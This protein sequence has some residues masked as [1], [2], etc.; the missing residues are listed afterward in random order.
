MSSLSAFPILAGFFF[1]LRGFNTFLILAFSSLF[2]ESFGSG[3]WPWYYVGFSILFVTTQGYL[4]ARPHLHG[5][6]FLHRALP[7]MFLL[8]LLLAVLFPHPTGWITFPA[9]I[10]YRSW[11]LHATQSFYDLVG[12]TWALQES[13]LHLPTLLA[14]GTLGSILAGVSLRLL[15]PTTGF[16]PLLVLVPLVGFASWLILSRYRPEQPTSSSASSTIPSLTSWATISPVHRRY[17]SMVFVISVM[18][19]LVVNL[20][21]FQFNAG[22][23]DLYAGIADRPARI[24][25]LLGTLNAVIEVTTLMLQAFAGRWFFTHLSLGSI[26]ALRPVLLGI[27]GVIT[28][29]LPSFWNITGFQYLSRTLTFVFMSPVWVLLLE[30]LP[31]QIRSYVRRLLNLIDC[32]TL[33]SLGLALAAWNSYNSGAQPVV[34][35]VISIIAL[36]T[37]RFNRSLLNLYPEMIRETLTDG[38]D[39][40]TTS[41]DGFKLLPPTA[42]RQ[43]LQRL[44]Q[45]SD[46]DVQLKAL[47][48]LGPLNLPEL[49]ELIRERLPQ[50]ND[51]TLVAGMTRFMLRS[52]DQ[53]QPLSAYLGSCTNP[54]RIADVLDAADQTM[55]PDFEWMFSSF[56]DHPHHRVRG[57]AVLSYLRHGVGRRLIP[58]ALEALAGL[59]EG[60]SARD[61]STA[62][63][64]MGRL[65][66]PV[67]ADALFRLV[68]DPSEDVARCAYHALASVGTQPVLEFVSKRLSQTGVRGTFARTCWNELSGQ[69]QTSLQRALAGMSLE[70]R[71]RTGIWLRALRSRL[72][73]SLLQRLLRLQPADRLPGILES[74]SESSP[75]LNTILDSC[76]IEQA[77]GSLVLNDTPL[78]EQVRRETLLQPVESLPLLLALTTPDNQMIRGWL[79]SQ[80]SGFMWDFARL[81]EI[82]ERASVQ[83]EE[84][85]KLQKTL[86]IRWS[87]FT[88]LLALLCP[89]EACSPETFRKLI[90]DDPQTSAL[91]LELL[92][93]FLP[94]TTFAM[95]SAILF[96]ARAPE[97]LRSAV[98]EAGFLDPR[99]LADHELLPEKESLP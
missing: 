11:D 4:L 6:P 41:L 70:E 9:L 59:R 25:A 80:L 27:F 3:G 12:K 77:D 68:D 82:R 58:Q 72:S 84:V 71:H 78:L 50:V 56:F 93:P 5:E 36:L 55:H 74:L 26:L 33:T 97:K 98:I 79:H 29:L 44:F 75:T 20:V 13:R 8:T 63:V 14:A 91:A 57:S 1:C 46:R 60:H 19:S 51:A 10:L 83:A 96:A 81:L 92:H 73:P 2:L 42:R 64:V 28:W 86:D 76:L 23:P 66:F 95:L 24:A 65:G 43:M 18:G 21:D 54:R 45:D 35:L 62:A 53:V 48:R 22:L 69:L 30:P 39:V 85:R 87:N 89:R 61:R 99:R 67:F 32:V 31:L 47:L 88:P 17:S 15:L 34:F 37:L 52:A 49:H 40:P 16:F 94:E 7:P 38:S 90:P